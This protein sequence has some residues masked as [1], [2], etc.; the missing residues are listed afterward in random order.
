LKKSLNEQWNSGI[1]LLQLLNMFFIQNKY[2]K[3]EYLDSQKKP[4]TA[5]LQ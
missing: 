1:S 3:E 4:S 2:L 5:I